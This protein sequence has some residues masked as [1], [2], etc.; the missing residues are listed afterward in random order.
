MDAEAD[1][2]IALSGMEK[3]RLKILLQPVMVIPPQ[4]LFQHGEGRL[5]EQVP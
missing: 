3:G 5:N 2:G 4:E 1:K